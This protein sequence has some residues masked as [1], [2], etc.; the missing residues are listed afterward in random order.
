MTSKSN[1]MYHAEQKKTYETDVLDLS[2]RRDSVETR[3]TPSPYNSSSFEEGSPST[4]H[5]SPSTALNGRVIESGI[6]SRST[7]P[8]QHFA[9][10]LTVHYRPITPPISNSNSYVSQYPRQ[11]KRETTSPQDN[12]KAYSSATNHRS[13]CAT[14]DM[15]PYMLE[16]IQRHIGQSKREAVSPI[17]SHLYGPGHPTKYTS[18]IPPLVHTSQTVQSTPV[19]NADP[20]NP[21]AYMIQ[22]TALQHHIA[23]QQAQINHNHHHHQSVESDESSENGSFTI[24]PSSYS[25]STVYPMVVGRDGK[26]TRPFKAYPRDPLSITASFTASDTIMDTQSAEK[27]QIFRKEMLKQIRAANGGQPTLSNPKMRRTSIKSIELAMCGS[28]SDGKH[29]D[30]DMHNL[31][32]HRLHNDTNNNSNGNSNLSDSSS[33]GSGHDRDGN[34]GGMTGSSGS[35]TKDSAYYERRKKN[36]AA[37]KKSRDR[38]RIKEDEIAIRANFLEREN[39]ELRIELAAARKQLALY[40]VKT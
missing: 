21:S 9:S 15:N 14:D 8:L 36:N 16:A 26:L 10:P 39:F 30:I 5:D 33:V 6:N 19:S 24:V 13:S 37:A 25:P 7:T 32:D 17:H 34:S 40:D 38:R 27:Y 2:R 35:C 12:N 20:M 31:N 11:P 1:Q 18:T 28:I 22:A 3:K 23:A 29:T 4:M